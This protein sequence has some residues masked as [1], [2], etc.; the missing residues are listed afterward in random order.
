MHKIEF[1]FLFEPTIPCYQHGRWPKDSSVA[2]LDKSL[3][4]YIVD[5]VGVTQLLVT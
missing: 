5:R 4:W 1:D 3:V 2:T